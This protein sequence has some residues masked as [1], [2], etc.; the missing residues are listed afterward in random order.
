MK[1]IAICGLPGSGKS[2]A[3]EAIND[4]GDIISMGDIVRNEAIKRNIVPN[5]FNLGK[6]AINLREDQ[7]QDIIAKKCV[8]LI[9]NCYT[10]DVLFID[11]IRSISE[12][13]LFRKFWKFPIIKI[14]LEEEERFKRLF[15]RAR[16]DDPKTL[17]EFR[18]RDSRESSFGL[19]E[20]LRIADYSIVNDSTPENLKKKMRELV[21]KISKNY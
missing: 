9:Q 21:Q 2:T 17:E 19:K 6:L 5:N 13:N 1:V 10:S 7:G 11:G 12:V 4:L 3:I 20:V 16:S 15:K 14:V 18:E 8:D